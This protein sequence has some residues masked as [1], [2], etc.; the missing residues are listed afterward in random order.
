M[1]YVNKQFLSCKKK[2][3]EIVAYSQNVT[4]FYDS[5]HKYS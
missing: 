4:G 1:L 3:K 2:K 5:I